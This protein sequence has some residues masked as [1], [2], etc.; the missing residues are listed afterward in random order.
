MAC[1]R[2]SRANDDLLTSPDE[3]LTP[4]G[5]MES[6]RGKSSRHV[7]TLVLMCGVRY[8]GDCGE[9]RWMAER[10][11]MGGWCGENVTFVD[12]EHRN[13]SVAVGMLKS[14]QKEQHLKDCTSF[15]SA[16]SYRRTLANVSKSLL[17]WRHRLPQHHHLVVLHIAD[18]FH[19]FTSYW[20]ALSFIWLFVSWLREFES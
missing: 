3:F 2:S 6:S 17:G 14:I 12:M 1:N 7:D 9:S 13:C 11:R 19:S 5:P 16:K 10:L 18:L 8:S 4:N 20:F 15:E